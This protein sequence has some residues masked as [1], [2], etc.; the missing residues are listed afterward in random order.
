[1]LRFPAVK[2]E[3]VGN[4]NALQRIGWV[5]GSPKNSLINV[6]SVVA[7][8]KGYMDYMEYLCQH[9]TEGNIFGH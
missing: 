9:W 5:E 3:S 7:P 8:W 4:W 6:L 1:M 2:L